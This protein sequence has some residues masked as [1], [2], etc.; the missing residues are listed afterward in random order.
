[1][2]LFYLPSEGKMIHQQDPSPLAL[3]MQATIL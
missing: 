2:I 3:K 1:M